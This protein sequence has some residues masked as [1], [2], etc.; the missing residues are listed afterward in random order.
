MSNEI[1]VGDIGTRFRLTILDDDTGSPVDISTATIKRIYM[2]SPT[3]ELKTFTATFVTDGSDGDIEYYTTSAS[4]LDVAGQ[5]KIQAEVIAPAFT[6]S[7]SISTFP[8]K[9]NLAP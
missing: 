4:D 3:R 1:H 8:V 7:T 9:K 2:T 5:W 6:N